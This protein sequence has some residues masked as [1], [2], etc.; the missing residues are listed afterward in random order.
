MANPQAFNTR[1][2]EIGNHPFFQAVDIERDIDVALAAKLAEVSL[3]DF[4]ALNPSANHPVIL[5]AGTPQILLPWDNAA[6][7][8]RN[9]RAYGNEGL[10]SWTVWQVPVTMKT[11]DAAKRVGMS[12]SELRS[13]NNIPRHV[14]IK[15]G[16]SLLVPRSA[17]VK[18]DVAEHLA[19]NGQLSLAPDVLLGRRVLR[20]GKKDTVAS[21]AR[22]YRISPDSIAEWNKVSTT[23]AFK[24]GQRV[25]LYLP[26]NTRTASKGKS[27]TVHRQA[28]SKT[29][30]TRPLARQ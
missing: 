7:F 1:L 10:A 16:S 8:G 3:I 17:G 21:L 6:V 23:A 15:A 29:V 5:A 14:R 24:A 28:R 12:E 30:K 22:R 18:T 19:D 2:P 27:R 11:V 26:K 20:A 13:A 9:L 4:K 25:V